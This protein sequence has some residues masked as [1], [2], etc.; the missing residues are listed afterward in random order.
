MGRTSCTEPQCLHK[1][2]FYPLPSAY[3]GISRDSCGAQDSNIKIIHTRTANWLVRTRRSNT[4]VTKELHWT[5]FSASYIITTCVPIT[6]VHLSPHSFI[7]PQCC[8]QTCILTKTLGLYANTSTDQATR[9]C[10]A[11]CN[12]RNSRTLAVLG[13]EHN[14]RRS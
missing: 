4:V 13:E 5:R 12:T 3:T 7:V 10:T 2:A 1:G 8:Q 14:S 6:H 11:R 9:T